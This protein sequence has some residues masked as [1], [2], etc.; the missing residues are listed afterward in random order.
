MSTTRNRGYPSYP[1]S[2]TRS[3]Q[4]ARARPPEDAAA[5]LAGILA[6][7]RLSLIYKGTNNLVLSHRDNAQTADSCALPMSSFLAPERRERREKSSAL[8]LLRID[9]LKAS[10]RNAVR[11]GSHALQVPPREDLG[12]DHPVL[13]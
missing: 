13:E 10:G 3:H 4:P 9:D 8:L 5:L 7:P 1:R 6:D 12:I 11:I 2:L